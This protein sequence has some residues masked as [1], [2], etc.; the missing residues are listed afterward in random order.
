MCGSVAIKKEISL[1]LEN[2]IYSLAIAYT[3]FG[4]LA[5]VFGSEKNIY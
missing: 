3:K 4:V 1:F 5:K 2:F